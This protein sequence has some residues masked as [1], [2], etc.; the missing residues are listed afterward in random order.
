[1]HYN[2]VFE[3]SNYF[4]TLV[5]NDVTTDIKSIYEVMRYI[6][7]SFATDF[8]HHLLEVKPSDGCLHIHCLAYVKN[9]KALFKKNNIIMRLKRKYPGYYL[10]IEA[11]K[12]ELHRTN[13]NA[14]RKMSN[15]DSA[16]Q[17]ILKG[18]NK[19][20]FKHCPYC[21]NHPVTVAKPALSHKKHNY[22]KDDWVCED[23]TINEAY[24]YYYYEPL[25]RYKKL[26]F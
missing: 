23:F 16:R 2:D 5:Q 7:K 25:I 8:K 4:F 12:T 21:A 19:G 9:R 20:H 14:Y 22:T 1:M 26:Y 10:R 11:I 18:Y 15:E 17:Y 13:I 6:T 24:V 3:S